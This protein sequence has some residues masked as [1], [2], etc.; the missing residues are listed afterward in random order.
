MESFGW[1]LIHGGLVDGLKWKHGIKDLKFLETYRL[2]IF[3]PGALKTS[4]SA[5]PEL[6]WMYLESSDQSR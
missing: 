1:S 4:L 3:L 2:W 5:A 6:V